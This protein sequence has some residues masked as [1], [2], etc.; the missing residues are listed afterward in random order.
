[1]AEVKIR[2]LP[3]TEW[4]GA[5]LFPNFEAGCAAVRTAMAQGLRPATLRLSDPTETQALMAEA[6]ETAR[7][8]FKTFLYRR[9][10]P[11]YLTW[12][13]LDLNKACL[14]LAVGEGGRGEAAWE[15][16]AL[17]RIARSHGGV[18]AGAGPARK[19]QETRFAAPYLRD[20]MI[21]RGLF[22]ETLETAAAWD[23]LSGLIRGV[24][25]ALLGS[26]SWPEQD[27]GK[28]RGLVMTHISHS[29]S[30]GANL[31]FTFLAPQ[32]PGREE[33]QW[34]RA[35]EAAV[36][37]ILD[38]GGALSHHHGVGRDHKPWIDEFWGRELLGLLKAAKTRL[39]PQAVLNPGVIFDPEA[40]EPEPAARYRPF[41]PQ[42]RRDNLDLFRREIFDVL[43]IGGG[44]VGAGVAWDAGLRG[45]S[46]ALVEKDDYAS[47]TSGK[48]SRLVHGGLRYLKMF[49]LRLVR[50]SLTERHNLLRMAPHLVKPSKFVLPIHKGEGDSKMLLSL[51]LW[52]YDTLAGSKGLP[53]HE[54]LTAKEVLDLEPSV[55]PEGLEG[56]QVYYDCLTDDARLTLETI[57]A[58]ART[59]AAT[60]NHMEVTGITLAPDTVEAEL[61]DKLTGAHHR[62]QARCVV[63]AAGVWSDKVRVAAD[64]QTK[65]ALRPAKGIHITYPRSLKPI[66][67]VVILKGNDGR[68]LFAVPSGEVVYIGTTDTDFTGDLDRPAAEAEEVDY[69]LDAV[70]RMFVGLPLTREQVIS[71][72]AGVRPLVAAGKKGET[73][74]ISRE[75][76]IK[77]EQTRLI[78]VRGGKLTTFRLMAAQT[79]EQVLVALGKESP[80]QSS[81]SE[82]SLCGPD[83]TVRINERAYPQRV[84]DRLRQKYGPQAGAILELAR[85]SRLSAVLD[86]SLGLT[87]AEIYWAVQGEMALTL[88]DAMVRRLGLMYMSPDNG[89]ELAP[90]VARVMA[91]VLGWTNKEVEAQLAEY[92]LLAARERA[93]LN[94]QPSF[95]VR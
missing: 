10:A 16:K 55:K 29:Y 37:V 95:P 39:D 74:D 36:R 7:G 51:G 81:T 28:K 42:T 50:E 85:D 9:L 59:G 40:S 78:T 66:N 71:S 79:V 1:E 88:C 15:R 83:H 20:E 75:H 87:A 21:T 17:N 84:L 60:V 76:E 65:T 31:Y 43:V 23:R 41:S 3:E 86:Q 47:G 63:N 13:G 5:Y 33:E 8:W 6:V 68:P 57:K 82:M 56:G 27:R 35:K 69:L 70:N 44:I 45:L 90:E 94:D 77:V 89:L 46:V 24:R 11:L 54:T 53:S 38:H 93:F 34:L 18:R 52:G 32:A 67:N 14:L 4:F 30:S 61:L 72:W 73:Q 25:E 80:P 62:V 19:W 22:V 26:L 12:W 48:S 64:P 58:A 49:D 92:C 2:P 91:A